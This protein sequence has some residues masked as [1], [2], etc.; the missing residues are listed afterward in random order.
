M[1]KNLVLSLQLFR[2][3]AELGDP[4]AHG[5]MGVRSSFGL[6]SDSTASWFKPVSKFTKVW[7]W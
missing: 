6:Q 3:A 1:P 2:R 4:E 5:E 7:V